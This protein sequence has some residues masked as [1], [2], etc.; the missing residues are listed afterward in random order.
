V[1]PDPLNP[2]NLSTGRKQ[3]LLQQRSNFFPHSVGEQ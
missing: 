1:I 3:K 2:E